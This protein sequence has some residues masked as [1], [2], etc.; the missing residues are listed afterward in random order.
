M[1]S[2]WPGSVWA[3]PVF[4][5]RLDEKEARQLRPDDT[6]HR[7]RILP[8]SN[9]ATRPGSAARS[10][11]AAVLC[12]CGTVPDL[13]KRQRTAAVQDAGA[14]AP[15]LWSIRF[16]GRML[17]A[18]DARVVLAVFLVATASLVH[19]Q[20]AITGVMS[21]TRSNMATGF[22]GAEYW[23]L[24]NFGTNDVNLDGYGFRDSKPDRPLVKYAFTNLVL[25]G[26]ES[27]VV[28]RLQYNTQSV[29]NAAQFR[30]WWGTN[31]AASV[32]FR[33]W[34][35][36]PGLSGWDGDEVW[37]FDGTG[38]LVD[39][40]Q[41]SRARVGRAF[42]YE[43]E[44]GLFGVFR[45]AGVD[46]AF[47]AELGDDAGSPGSHAGPVAV[48]FLQQPT[49]QVVDANSTAT[50][51][52]VASAMP[53][54]RYPW[55]GRGAPIAFGTNA[56]LTLPN[57][58]PSN[59]GEYFLVISNVPGVRGA[60]RAADGD[61][62]WTDVAGGQVAVNELD[63]IGHAG[64]RGILEPGLVKLTVLVRR[65]ER[66][67]HDTRSPLLAAVGFGGSREFAHQRHARAT[68]AGGH[69]RAPRPRLRHE[70][71]RAADA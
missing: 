12:R 46:G 47:A 1:K 64:E 22:R 6:A 43:P 42:T 65:L 32:P 57:A 15:T 11:T 29:T 44:N 38:R 17:A 27:L 33:T 54:P 21:V 26:G 20:L 66:H 68:S 39:R 40:V 37:L 69:A 10:W 55:F 25:R 18:R 59:A 49:D 51:T 28:F 60:F 70:W 4:E 36:S 9:L 35:D 56:A 19:A 41:F 16:A 34:N 50:F 71:P 45:V 52:A 7:V 48:R 14:T 63:A 53:Q 62:R 5:A 8:P 2:S 61:V 24:T 23:E 3:W 67:A 31:I 13:E 58:Q 30:A